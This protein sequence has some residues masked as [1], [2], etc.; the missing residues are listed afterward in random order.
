MRSVQGALYDQHQFD[1]SESSDGGEDCG[2]PNVA[3]V[4]PPATV[5]T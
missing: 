3:L 5:L 2:G 1:S 4:V